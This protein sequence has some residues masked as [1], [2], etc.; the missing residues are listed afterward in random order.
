MS[1]EVRRVGWEGGK[2]T[3]NHLHHHPDHHRIGIEDRV[4]PPENTK[5]L[6]H[7]PP[8]ARAVEI[9]GGG[10]GVMYQEPGRL[11]GDIGVFLA[12]E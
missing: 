8:H 4:I 2:V 3:F 11:A 6:P 12:A 5:I 10:H 9:Q 7:A 1:T